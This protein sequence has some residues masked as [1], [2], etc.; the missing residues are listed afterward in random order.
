MTAS[1][2]QTQAQA[3]HLTQRCI[4]RLHILSWVTAGI[5]RACDADHNDR[6]C[7]DNWHKPN[8]L[9]TRRHRPSHNTWSFLCPRGLV[10]GRRRHAQ[11]TVTEHTH[12]DVDVNDI[13]RETRHDDAS[14]CG[15]VGSIGI[16]IN[17][18]TTA[19]AIFLSAA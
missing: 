18:Y 2:H 13:V 1:D 3:E 5:L 4:D 7:S 10:L 16:S 9:C 11:T 6:I 14:V 19:D 8:A 15:V 12:N 17:A